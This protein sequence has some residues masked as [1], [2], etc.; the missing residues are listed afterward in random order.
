MS[1]QEAKIRIEKLKQF[2]KK[3]NEEYFL[4]NKTIVPESARDQM[5]RELEDLEREY[6]EFVTSDSPTQ[7]IGAPLSGRLK[8]VKHKTRKF[9]LQDVFQEEEIA[10]WLE[11]CAR[12]LPKERFEIV[13]ELKIDGLNITLWYEKGVLIKALTRGDA[14]MGEDVTHTVRTIESIPLQLEEEITAEISGEVYMKHSDFELIKGSTG[15]ANPRN[16]AA[17]AVRQ[18][19][20]KIAAERH[21]SAF[22]YTFLNEEDLDQ[23]HMLQRLKKLGFPTELHWKLHQDLSGVMKFIDQWDKSKE[24]L[25]YGIDGIVLKINSAKQRSRLGFTARTPRWAVAY[26]FAAEQA[27]TVVED[28]VFQV[29]RTGAITPV[30]I[31]K[32]TLV[33]GS[34]ISRATLHNEDELQKK[35]VRIGDTVILHKAGEVIPEIIRVLPE[36]RSKH[37]QVIHFPKHCPICSSTLNRPAGEA[38]TRCPNSRC[39]GRTRESYY[40][41]VSK[42]GFNIEALG[43]KIIDQLLDRQLITTPADIFRLTFDEIYSLDLFEK[44]RTENLLLAIA[45]AKK[46][47]FSKC[48]FA[49][50]I[51]HIGEQSARDLAQEIQRHLHWKLDT[52]E[53]NSPEEILRFVERNDAREIIDSIE[54]IGPKIIEDFFHWFSESEHRHLILQLAHYGVEIVKEAFGIEHDK[55]FEGKTFVIT[56]TFDAYSREELKSIVLRKGGK[57]SSSVSP[58]TDVVL[59][60]ENPGSKLSKAK[61][62]GVEVWDERKI[63]DI[64]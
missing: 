48:L 59:V 41:F 58:K 49:L 2:L 42:K 35:D 51:P 60:G 15:F 37:S 28:I 3:W 47:P 7:R 56:G 16:A 13:S 32:P 54:G 52:T 61:E 8:K 34:T 43:E 31:L 11:R 40:H 17:G 29:G 45:L 53:V 18:L 26:K 39:P 22:F 38:I 63:K 44:K 5:K 12:V 6:P 30:A 25:D 46:I 64:F 19:N 23:D 36:L 9:S 10:D 21:L 20:P 50:G 57:V 62:Y 1:K 14:V 33:A 4:Q 24:R 27:S 55:R